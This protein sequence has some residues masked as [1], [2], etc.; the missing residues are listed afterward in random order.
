[1]NILIIGS[2][3]LGL[4]AGIY[5]RKKGHTVTGTT[6]SIEKMAAIEEHLNK[7]FLITKDTLPL[8]FKDQDVVLFTAAADNSQLYKETYLDNAIAIVE[9]FRHNPSLKQVIYSGSTSVYGEHQG[10]EVREDTPLNPLTP[11]SQILIDTENTLR[12]LPQSCIF[13]MGELIGNG[14]TIEDRLIRADG[15]TMAGSGDS[16]TNFSPLSDVIKAIDFAIEKPLFGIFNLCSTLHAERKELY[17]QLSKAK[18]LPK[19]QWD[20]GTSTL[21]SGNKTVISERII[22]SGF[23]FE[24]LPWEGILNTTV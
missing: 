2:G 20:K 24:A 8:A 18:G 21:H 4:A 7:A 13:R 23:T 17:T 11:Q 22:E 12:T 15:A 16:I 9:A 5:L 6:R 14:R 19:V 10:K 1:M 3:Y